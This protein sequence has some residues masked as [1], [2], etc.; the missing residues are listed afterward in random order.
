[1]KRFALYLC[2]LALPLITVTLAEEARSAM[3]GNP[4]TGAAL[5]ESCVPCHTLTGKGLAGKPAD[6]LVEK[7][8]KYQTVTSDNPKVQAM[9]K[10][11]APMSQQDLLDL[12]AYIS[13]M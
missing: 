8:K 5:Y 4:A 6:T 2:L 1:M 7:M 10:A 9:Q 3:Q 11:L 13:K 12:A